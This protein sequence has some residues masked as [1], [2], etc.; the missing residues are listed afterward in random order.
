M[1]ENLLETRDSILLLTL[2]HNYNVLKIKK[3]DIIKM[4]IG[5]DRG[6]TGKVLRV[7]PKNYKITVEG[8]NLLVKHIKPR[9]ENEKGQRAK[10]PAPFYMSKARIVCSQCGKATRVGFKILGDAAKMRVC[11][12]CKAEFK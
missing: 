7:Y 11:K 5:K 12:K 9:R 2:I 3:G 8:I 6:K 1:V 10:F 4:M